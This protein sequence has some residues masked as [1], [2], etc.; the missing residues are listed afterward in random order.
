M[1]TNLKTMWREHKMLLVLT[2]AVIL[3]QMLVG[4]LLWDRLP[5][6][7]ATHFNFHNEPDGWTSKPFAVFGMPLLLLGLHIMCLLLSC[8]SNIQMQNV[9][10]RVKSLMLLIIPAA[11]LLVTVLCYGYA[12]GAPFAIDRIVWVFVGVIFALVGNYLPKMRRNATMGIRLPWTL[13][14]DEVWNR[15]HRFAAPVWVLCGLLMIVCGLIG[16][17][18]MIPIAAIVVVIGLPIAYSLVINWKKYR[19]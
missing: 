5:D 8:M 10:S 15:T 18:P 17:G 13:A 4:V 12:L 6:P 11:S 3:L 9:S 7:M 2:S 1:K 19:A 16:S 14:D